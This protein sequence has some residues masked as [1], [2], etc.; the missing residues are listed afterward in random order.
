MRASRA[1]DRPSRA[2]KIRFCIF[3]HVFSCLSMFF[4]NIFY[5]GDLF[6]QKTQLTKHHGKYMAAFLH[7][8]SCFLIANRSAVPLVRLAIHAGNDYKDHGAP[9]SSR[10][11]PHLTC[12]RIARMQIY[13]AGSDEKAGTTDTSVSFQTSLRIKVPWIRITHE[14]QRIEQETVCANAGVSIRI[15]TYGP[16][17]YIDVYSR[18]CQGAQSVHPVHC[19]AHVSPQTLH[20]QI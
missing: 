3:Y 13:Q 17:V 14:K 18:R 20:A 6:R 16:S 2:A 8:F 4:L 10:S 7:V 19:R 5:E 15:S 1:A 9:F 11:K 12:A